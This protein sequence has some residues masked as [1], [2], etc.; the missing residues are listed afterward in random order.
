MRNWK[1]WTLT[2]HP[3]WICPQTSILTH[4]HM[5]ICCRDCAKLHSQVSADSRLTHPATRVL[6]SRLSD[7]RIRMHSHWSKGS[8]EC[9]CMTEPVAVQSQHPAP[10]IHCSWNSASGTARLVWNNYCQTL[11]TL[12]IQTT[13]HEQGLCL[14]SLGKAKQRYCCQLTEGCSMVTLPWRKYGNLHTGMQAPYNV[15]RLVCLLVKWS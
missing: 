11:T 5:Q 7:S 9:A 4:I 8:S 13:M 14:S 3:T 10:E 2:A 1:S 15:V 12:L 6:C